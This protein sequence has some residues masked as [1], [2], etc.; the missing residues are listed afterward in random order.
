MF[1]L[2]GHGLSFYPQSYAVGSRPQRRIVLLK[3]FIFSHSTFPNAISF[4]RKGKAP[5]SAAECSNQS[6]AFKS[7]SASACISMQKPLYAIAGCEEVT[8]DFEMPATNS[9]YPHYRTQLSSS[10]I[11]GQ[12][13]RA[14]LVKLVCV[15]LSST[16]LGQE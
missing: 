12:P 9:R 1:S 7:D 14:N 15:L 8:N 3:T 5:I 16:T 11:D 13:N 6:I 4:G 10:M 2:S